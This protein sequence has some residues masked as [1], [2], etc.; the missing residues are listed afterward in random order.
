MKNLVKKNMDKYH[1]MMDRLVVEL[2]WIIFI[3]E[4]NLVSILFHYYHTITLLKLMFCFKNISS[5]LISSEKPSNLA[6]ESNV[7]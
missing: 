7:P 4:F 5:Q 2:S 1:E 6:I 3:M